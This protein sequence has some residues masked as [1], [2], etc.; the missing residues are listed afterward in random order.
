M[1]QLRRH[2]AVILVSASILAISALA[3]PAANAASGPNAGPANTSSVVRGNG[4][5]VVD[6]NGPGVVH[7]GDATFIPTGPLDANTR[8][9]VKNDDGTLPGGQTLSGLSN[10]ATSGITPMYWCGSFSYMSAPYTWTAPL[11][12]QCALFGSPGLQ[13]SYTFTVT[14]ETNQ[15]AEAQGLGFYTGYNGSEFGVWQQWYNLG[16][17]DSTSLGGW[18]V[19]WGN[20][21]AYPKFRARSLMPSYAIGFWSY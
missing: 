8:I 1:K 14:A 15:M 16:T 12:S 13:L 11:V 5:I 6:P 19:P 18:T 21:E 10:S 4:F 17:A 20:V 2:S 9:V 3:G 7:Q